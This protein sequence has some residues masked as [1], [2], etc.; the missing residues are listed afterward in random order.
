MGYRHYQPE[1]K[2]RERLNL[3]KKHEPSLLLELNPSKRLKQ[4]LV[5]V[6]VLALGSSIA[7]ALPIVVKLLLPI[8]IC[9]HLYFIIKRLKDRRYSIKHT[10]IS[11][12]EI[13]D[14]NGFE[15]VQILDSTVI[16]VFA[17]FLHFHHKARRQSVLI[18]NDALTEDDYR[19]FI[20]RLKTAN[21]Q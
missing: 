7:N 19:R 13:S 21:R 3:A 2:Y 15:Q 16:T 11:G 9:I 1:M 17:I 14:G 12:W 8:G 4:L 18:V 5:A 10:E 20:V 6:H